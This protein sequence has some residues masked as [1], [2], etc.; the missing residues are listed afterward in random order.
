MGSAVRRR[1]PRFRRRGRSR[2]D[3]RGGDIARDGKPVDELLL[4]AALLA[5]D[6]AVGAHGVEFLDDDRGGIALA[7][8]AGDTGGRVFTG[9]ESI[10][11]LGA[12]GT[13]VAGVHDAASSLA[14]AVALGRSASS[15]LSA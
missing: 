1:S 9:G 7:D 5:L 14:S 3:A 15:C 10:G 13:V 11:D 4:L 2:L 6:L 8:S 12:Q